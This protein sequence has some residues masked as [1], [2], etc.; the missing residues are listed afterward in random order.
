MV[1]ADQSNYNASAVPPEWHAWLHHISDHT[2]E[3]VCLSFRRCLITYLIHH[4]C[5]NRKRS[6]ALTALK[7]LHI[8]H[9]LV[10]VRQL[11]LCFDGMAA[12]EVEAHKIWCGSQGELD[13]SW[14]RHDSHDQR[15]CS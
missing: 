13:R 1:Y 12:D 14:R 6:G 7:Y 8:L 5:N 11:I 3:E 4:M 9:P 2:A 15:S 10:H